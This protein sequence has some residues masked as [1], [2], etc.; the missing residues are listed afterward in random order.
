[1]Y[2]LTFDI[3]SCTPY[4]YQRYDTE[5][6]RTNLMNQARND[7]RNTPGAEVWFVDVTRSEIITGSVVS[8]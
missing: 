5:K 6:D 2:F 7:M 8:E 1:M 4:Q 3:N